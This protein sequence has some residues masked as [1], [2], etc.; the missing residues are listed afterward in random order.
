[1]YAQASRMR[2]KEA[3]EHMKMNLQELLQENEI[4]RTE[5]AALKQRLA[6]FEVV[7]NS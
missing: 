2:K 5:N 7:L 1:M 6:F 4:L 3:D